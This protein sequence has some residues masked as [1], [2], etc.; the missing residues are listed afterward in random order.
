M[1]FTDHTLKQAHTHRSEDVRDPEEDSSTTTT[2][3]EEDS[4]DSDDSS[5]PCGVKTCYLRGAIKKKEQQE[6]F[7]CFATRDIQPNQE[8]VWNYSSHDKDAGEGACALS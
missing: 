3:T 7:V 5:V 1:P 8:C 4:E 6:L 2:S